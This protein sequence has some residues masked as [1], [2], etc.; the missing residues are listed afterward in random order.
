MACTTFQFIHNFEEMRY[1][2]NII[3]GPEFFLIKIR[4]NLF[5][6]SYFLYLFSMVCKNILL[7]ALVLIKKVLILLNLNTMH[8]IYL[9]GAIYET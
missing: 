3:W 9:F 1:S 8:Y 6:F 5:Y 4:P 2:C 7:L